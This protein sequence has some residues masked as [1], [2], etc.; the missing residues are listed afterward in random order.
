[1]AQVQRYN[2]DHSRCSNQA[3]K[4]I[5]SLNKEETKDLLKS[6]IKTLTRQ[7]LDCILGETLIIDNEENE[8]VSVSVSFTHEI[9]ITNFKETIV[10]QAGEAYNRVY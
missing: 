10:L 2:D 3:S 5:I 1:M 8:K 7:E 4:V 9:K 6:F